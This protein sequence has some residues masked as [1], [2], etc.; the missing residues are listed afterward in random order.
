MNAISIKAQMEPP[1]QSNNSLGQRRTSDIESSDHWLLC[2]IILDFIFGFV[3]V[4]GNGSLFVTIYRDPCNCLRS[5]TTSLIANLSVADFFMGLVSLLRAVELLYMYHG[6]PDMPALNLIGYFIAAV[7]ILAA[8]STLMTMSC[9]RYVAVVQPFRYRQLITIRR[10]KVTI[11]GIWISALV[12]CVLPISHVKQEIFLLT[13][14]YSHFVIP[15]FVLTVIYV[16]IYKQITSQRKELKEVRESMSS[17]NRIRQLERERRMV[18]AFI[19]ILIVFFCSFLPYFIFV[20]ILFFCPCRES[21]AFHMFR[22]I[23]NEFLSLSSVV[24]PFMYAWRIPTFNRSFRSC[25]QLLKGRNVITVLYQTTSTPI[26]EARCTPVT[27]SSNKLVQKIGIHGKA[28]THLP[29]MPMTHRSKKVSPV[30]K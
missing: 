9:E 13:Y 2:F 7:S 17:A 27:P 30:W 18:M 1:F 6:V 26:S 21:G 11:G 12:L 20:Q 19:L 5:P 8:V 3:I 25:F 16:K 15:S 23:M 4:T 29:G 10:T 28:G 24:D 14:S 22:L